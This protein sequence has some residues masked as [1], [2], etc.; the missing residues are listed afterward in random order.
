MSRG[1][2]VALRPPVQA[3]ADM[4][5][6]DMAGSESTETTP[7]SVRA[8]DDEVWARM[9]QT[10]TSKD[11][12]GTAQDQT[13]LATCLTTRPDSEPLRKRVKFGGEPFAHSMLPHMDGHAELSPS[14][15]FRRS[16]E[17]GRR[18]VRGNIAPKAVH[19]IGKAPWL[20]ANCKAHLDLLAHL[21]PED[22]F[23]LYEMKKVFYF[24]QRSVIDAL[25]KVFFESVYPLMPIIDRS[26]VL[27]FCEDMY[28]HAPSSPLLLHSILFTSCQYADLSIVLEA[29]FQSLAD[30]KCYFY[31]CAKVLY[32]HDCEP[33]SLLTVQAL[34]LLGFWWADYCEEKDMRFW[35]GCAV[36]MALG[37]GMHK[38]VPESMNMPRSQNVVW[39][40]LFW[41]LYVSQ[42]EF[43]SCSALGRKEADVSPP[44]SSRPVSTPLPSHWV[45]PFSFVPPI[46]ISNLFLRPILTRMTRNHPE[47]S[48]DRTYQHVFFPGSLRIRFI[49]QSSKLN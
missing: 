5:R 40:R 35:V 11:A 48:P 47:G 1:S 12:A 15:A 2:D 18:L 17:P 20:H 8:G 28:R 49:Q 13:R 19:P 14:T 44:L 39:R 9:M 27:C 29:G 16:S 25:V 7:Q 45:C 32:C 31:Q 30:A 23:Y 38:P 46:A 37:M 21:A 36:N 6:A 24:P 3:N 42:S 43:T 10:M 22:Q 4:V 33:D 41:S 34:A 26:T